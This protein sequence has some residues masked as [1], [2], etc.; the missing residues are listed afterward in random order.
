MTEQQTEAFGMRI[1][2]ETAADLE[3]IRRI[4][5]EAFAQHPI[6]HQ[7]EHLI[8][9][10]LRAADAL[11]LS[12]VAVVDGEVV[13]HIAFS[14]VPIGE[15]ASGWLLLGP[16]AVL[17]RYQGQGIGSALVSAGLAESRRA[18]APG[19]VLVGEPAFYGRFGFVA[20]RSAA[21]EG[22][23]GEFLLC[24]PFSGG[25]PIGAVVAHAAFSIQPDTD[26]AV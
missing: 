7:T 14:P 20:C 25:E 19:C 26:G 5:L 22:V 2:P 3:A 21:Y 18:G 13:G 15:A 8:V 24:V 12:L 16:V 6:S 17:P 1:R 11:A 10:A 9:D 23:P 4:N